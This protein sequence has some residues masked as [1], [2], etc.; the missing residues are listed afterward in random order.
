MQQKKWETSKV[1][2]KFGEM[3]RRRKAD[4]LV[5]LPNRQ[6]RAEHQPPV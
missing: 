4:L 1:R 6:N 3:A 2:E 5:R